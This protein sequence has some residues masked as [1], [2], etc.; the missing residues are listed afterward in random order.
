MKNNQHQNMKTTLIIITSAILL[1]CSYPKKGDTTGFRSERNTVFYNNDTIATLSAIEYSI[2]NGKLV[3]DVTFK[4]SN[5]NHADRVQNF[6]YFVHEKHKG[7][8]GELDYPI[9]RFKI[10]KEQE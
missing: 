8:D 10:N 9:T 2:D 5:M 7:W 3:K 6:L 4:L 1:G